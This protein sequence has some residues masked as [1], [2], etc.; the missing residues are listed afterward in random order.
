MLLLNLDR[1]T[2]KRNCSVLIFRSS[3]DQPKFSHFDTY[4]LY[5]LPEYTANFFFHFMILS[6]F[7]P[8]LKNKISVIFKLH[9]SW[10]RTGWSRTIHFHACFRSDNSDRPVLKT[11]NASVQHLIRHKFDNGSSAR[12]S[13][14]FFVFDFVFFC[15]G[16][17]YS[18]R[19]S[20]YYSTNMSKLT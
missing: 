8:F 15:E 14:L 3:V 19:A 7:L 1:K 11:L 13:V 12:I 20:N 2:M 4:I 10:P 6:K 18:F 5:C 17:W 16:G 9:D